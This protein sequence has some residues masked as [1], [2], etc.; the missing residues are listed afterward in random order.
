MVKR[1]D[2]DGWNEKSDSVILMGFVKSAL[3]V[4]PCMVI[5]FVFLY[6][7]LCRG[8]SNALK[9]L[10]NVKNVPHFVISRAKGTWNRTNVTAKVLF[11]HGRV[12]LQIC[13]KI[14]EPFITRLKNIT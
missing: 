5:N 9:Q 13:L 6:S 1:Q 2:P 7:I 4:N 8:V 11:F 14:L 10:F 3:T 12:V